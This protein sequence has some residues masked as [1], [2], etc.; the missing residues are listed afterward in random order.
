MKNPIWI[1]ALL[2]DKD[3]RIKKSF[4]NEAFENDYILFFEHDPHYECCTLQQ[5]ERGIRPKNFFRLDE[6]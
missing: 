6:I 5:M 4:L 1:E 2:L 3:M